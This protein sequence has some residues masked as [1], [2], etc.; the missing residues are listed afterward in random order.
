MSKK[1][2]LKQCLGIDVSM[3]KIDC[4]LSFFTDELKVKAVASRVFDNNRSGFVKLGEWLDKKKEEYLV[5]YVNMEATGTYHEEAAYFLSDVG[6]S[7]SI[8]QP[9]KGKQYAKSLDE[10]NKTDKSDASMLARMGLERQLT[11]WNRPSDKMRVLKRLS[12]ERMALIRDRNSLTNQL[13]ALNHS[14][15][16]FPHSVERLEERVLLASRQL[17]DIEKQMRELAASDPELWKRICHTIT[18]PGINFVTA[19]TVI[20]ETDGFAN[21]GGRRQLVSYVGLDVIMKESGTLSWRPRISKRGNAHIRAALYMAGVCSIIH[22]KNLKTYFNQ[23]KDRGKPG[24]TG[25][26]ALERK[27]LVLIYTLYKNEQD[28]ITDYNSGIEICNVFESTEKKNL[29]KK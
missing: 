29:L 24:R 4:C 2:I 27:L 17:V 20:A 8:I 13:H 11:S 19:I 26:V 3:K 16:A 12:R 22:N 1:A 14:F 6:Y 23:L 18:I 28:Y 9:A 10:K 5:M 7:L 25:I 15:Q 21:I